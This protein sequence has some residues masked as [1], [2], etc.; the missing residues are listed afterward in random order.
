METAHAGE[1]VDERVL[2][3]LWLLAHVKI[4][5]DT[6]LFRNSKKGRKGML[7]AVTPEKVHER[8]ACLLFFNGKPPLR[9]CGPAQMEKLSF[10]LFLF[11]KMF[12][13]VFKFNY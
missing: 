11:W 4:V 2:R 3:F 7:R 9:E 10:L 5:P 1:Q 13:L 6:R 8:L 12:D